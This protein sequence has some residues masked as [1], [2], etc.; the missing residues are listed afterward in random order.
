MTP[1]NLDSAVYHDDEAARLHLESLRWP[2]GAITCALCG[3]TD[4]AR[5]V[6]GTSMGPGW[7][8]CGACQ[9]KF[10]VRTGTVYERSHIALHKWMLGFRLYAASKK[11]FSAHQLHRT[12]GITYKSAWFMA[13]RI[14]EAMADHDPA[15][16]GGKDKVVEVDETFTGKNVEVFVNG[17]GW[18][19]KASGHGMSKVL[20][21]VERGGRARSVK[22]DTL[23]AK[24][25]HPALAIVSRE[26]TLNT[27]EA[28]RYERLGKQFA[29]H[30]RVHHK[31][32]EYA[33]GDA[34]TNTV[35]GFFSIFK[36][37]M[38][39]V[40]QHCGEQHLQRYLYEFDFRYSNRSA[41]G[42]EDAERT[43]RAIKGAVGKRLTYRQPR[44]IA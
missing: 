30:N 21:V 19:K 27:D 26:S 42:V 33:R 12:L 43:E 20:T 44:R 28:K 11:G 38:K 13:H 32:G 22:V 18:R 15:P 10:T 17:K 35:E 8:Y 1:T 39:G 4:Q 7:F 29:K 23:K 16:I 3:S 40:Y 41:L 6:D 9:S 34:S 24:D 25:V 36:R 5:P 2:N 31:E 37:G 14:R